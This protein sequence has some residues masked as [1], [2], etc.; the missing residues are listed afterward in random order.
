MGHAISYQPSAMVP[1]GLYNAQSPLDQSVSYKRYL[2]RIPVAI[3]WS[4]TVYDPI[5]GSGSTTA[6]RFRH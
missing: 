1:N 6:N 3:F 5:T 2:H 4:V